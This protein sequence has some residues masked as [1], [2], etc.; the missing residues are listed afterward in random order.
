M[1]DSDRLDPSEPSRVKVD[2]EDA[3]LHITDQSVMFEKGGRVSGFERSAIR[4]VKSDGDAMIIAYTAGN[5]VKSVRVEPMTAVASLLV[6]ITKSGSAAEAA[7]TSA[8]ALDETFEKLYRVARKELEQKLD[9]INKEPENMSLRLTKDEFQRYIQVRNQMWNIMGAKYGFNPYAAGR[10]E[11]SFFDLDKKQADRQL[12]TIKVRYVDFLKMLASEKA[13][14][15]DAFYAIDDV[16]PEEWDKLLRHFGQAEK[17]L[18]TERW[19]QFFD[20]LRPKW[21]N[22]PRGNRTEP[23]IRALS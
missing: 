3:F 15:Q 9:R 2:G 16:W 23:W 4:M 5:E 14:G 13:E 7:Q 10:N 19:R 1:S 17:T 22:R 21:T 6:S 12:D 8:T 20:Y 11:F 18:P